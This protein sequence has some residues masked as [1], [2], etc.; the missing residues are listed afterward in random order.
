[1]KKH[2]L[3]IRLGVILFLIVLFA[4]G[5]SFNLIFINSHS[6]FPSLSAAVGEALIFSLTGYFAV[7]LVT[8]QGHLAKKLNYLKLLFPLSIISSLY[9][10]YLINSYRVGR[11]YHFY[12]YLAL[13][14]LIFLNFII[15]DLISRPEKEFDYDYG[16][17]VPPRYYRKA[18]LKGLLLTL[19]R[20]I[21][22]PL[23]LGLYEV[24]SPGKKSPII[25]TGNYELTVRRVLR[26]LKGYDCR[27]LVCNSR[28]INI[29]CSSLAG[30]FGSDDIIEALKMSELD[31][32]TEKRKLIL[33]QLAAVNIDRDEIMRKTG[34][35]PV[36]GPVEIEHIGQYLNKRMSP[37]YREVKFGLGRRLEMALGAPLISL[38]IL[39]LAYNFV[40][41]TRLALILP[42]LYLFS[43]LG[44]ALYPYR[45]LKNSYLWSLVYGL[46][47]LVVIYLPARV[48]YGSPFPADAFVTAAF[49]A[50]LVLEFAGWSP[51]VKFSFGS[52]RTSGP[53]VDET[54]CTGCTLCSEVCPRAVF[55]MEGRLS[56]AVSPEKCIRCMACKAQCHVDALKFPD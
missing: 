8:A 35:I 30:H 26:A 1:M 56:R 21:P 41:L 15:I 22:Y 55:K 37:E 9:G 29:W 54:L 2:L 38:F 31:K 7:Y 51:L 40:G 45:P 27:L 14:T 48:L 36:F 49:S 20:L 53:R 4:G 32:K 5:R 3:L 33:P 17:R 42:A 24:G 18:P 52:A 34:F 12:I 25:V 44:G 11:E 46:L 19:L 28:G 13:T 16:E 43:L 23:P 47:V 39:I 50:Y 6:P 10:R